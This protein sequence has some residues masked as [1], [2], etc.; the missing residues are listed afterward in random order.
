[1]KGRPPSSCSL[2]S[3][4]GGGQNLWNVF[5]VDAISKISDEIGKLDVN[6]AF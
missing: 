4:N 1:M 6:G 3:M 2:D 5:T